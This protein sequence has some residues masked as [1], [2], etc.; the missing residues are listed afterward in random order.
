M[1][2][3]ASFEGEEEDEDADQGEEEENRQP[4]NASPFPPLDHI[5]LV[6]ASKP[7][8]PL[9]CHPDKAGQADSSFTFAISRSFFRHC[10]C[11]EAGR[12]RTLLRLTGGLRRKFLP[13]GPCF[14]LSGKEEN[15]RKKERK[16]EEREKFTCFRF[17]DEQRPPPSATWMI[18]PRL[19]LA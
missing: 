11:D 2:E 12:K 16:E 7:A 19:L 9:S 17:A 13:S 6:V 14:N 8:R 3:M 18:E 4:H 15:R 1:Q 10:Y 5:H